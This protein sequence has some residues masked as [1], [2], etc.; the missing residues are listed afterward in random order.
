MLDIAIAYNRYK[1]LG[2]EFL[3]WLWFVMETDPDLFRQVDDECVSFEIGDKIVLEKREKDVLEVVS[4]KGDNAGREEGKLSLKK[5]SVVTA[6]NLLYHSGS[7]KWRFSLKGES[8]GISGLKTPETGRVETREDMEGAIL[9]KIFLVEKAVSFL[10]S[11]FARF[12]G[13]RL[14]DEW[15][16]K[17]VP[18][19]KKWI[20][21]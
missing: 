12:L 7:E 13:V 8:F 19:M 20:Q 1:F 16:G 10:K 21:T 14:S 6:M 17:W 2:N 11:L 4:I 3:T 9:E 5:G 15:E 18:K